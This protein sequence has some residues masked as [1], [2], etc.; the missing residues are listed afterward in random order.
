MKRGGWRY[1]QKVVGIT[2][3]D[4]SNRNRIFVRERFQVESLTNTVRP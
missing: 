3:E 4:G 1:R 2:Y